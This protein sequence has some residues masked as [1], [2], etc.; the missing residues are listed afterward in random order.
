MSFCKKKIEYNTYQIKGIREMMYGE[1]CLKRDIFMDIDN[2]AI[3]ELIE[4]DL[5]NNSIRVFLLNQNGF[6]FSNKKDLFSTL[7]DKNSV[8]KVFETLSKRYANRKG[9]YYRVLK[10]GFRTGDDAPMAIIELVDWDINAIIHP[11][12]NIFLGV[13]SI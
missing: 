10:E 6:I 4:E 12:I 2:L 13:D 9:G 3:S 1:I 7:Q 5:I 8:K 11:Y